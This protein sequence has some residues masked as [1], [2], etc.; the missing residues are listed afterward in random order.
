MGGTGSPAS[1]DSMIRELA[2]HAP[3]GERV[4]PPTDDQ[5]GDRRAT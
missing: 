5:R 1:T 3:T 2:R 4:G